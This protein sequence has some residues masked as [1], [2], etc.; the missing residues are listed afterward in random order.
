M[1]KDTDLK[2]SVKK[3]IEAFEQVF[4]KDWDYT[5]DQLGIYDDTPEQKQNIL[6]AGL[7]TLY[8]ISP[9]GTFIHP[10]VDDEIE[11]WGHRGLLLDEYR[12]LK[13][14]LIEM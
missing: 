13:K 2:E 14:L 8:M 10:K 12:R 11:N 1:K 3:F 7:E 6:D 5:K 9:N 4:D